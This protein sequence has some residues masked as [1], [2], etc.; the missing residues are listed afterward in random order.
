MFSSTSHCT[1]SIN[2][3]RRFAIHHLSRFVDHRDEG[4]GEYRQS[5]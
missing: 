3:P 4:G 5:V 1:S 2:F